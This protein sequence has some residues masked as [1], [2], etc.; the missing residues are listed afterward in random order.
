MEYTFVGVGVIVIFQ[1]GVLISYMKDIS[2]D[3][4]S[5]LATIGIN[6]ED[7]LAI[8]SELDQANRVLGKLED[9]L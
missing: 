8:Q 4:R 2:A 1:L 9:R 3:L 5:M 6:H 7:V